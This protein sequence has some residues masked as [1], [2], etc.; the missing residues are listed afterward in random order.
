M[1]LNLIAFTVLFFVLSFPRE[2]FAFSFSNLFGNKDTKS[3]KQEVEPYHDDGT[4]KSSD[5]EVSF[6]V[7]VYANGESSNGI[8]FQ[9]TKRQC[10]EAG[11]KSDK[12]EASL[13]LNDILCPTGFVALSE[14]SRR[15][16][17]QERKLWD[18]EVVH[19]ENENP[20]AGF[21]CALYNSCGRPIRTCNDLIST[22]TK[23]DLQVYETAKL[24]GDI[25]TDCN[26]NGLVDATSASRNMIWTVPIAKDKSLRLFMWPTYRIGHV[27]TLRNIAEE[28]PGSFSDTSQNPIT[29]TTI[30][31]QPKV[32]RIGNFIT[33]EESQYLITKHNDTTQPLLQ[34]STTGTREHSKVSDKRSSDTAFDT[35]SHIALRLKKRGFRVAGIPHYDEQLA[36]GIQM[37]RYN[38][39]NA[40]VTHYDW[41]SPT[42]MPR[43]PAGYRYDPSAAV[44]ASTSGRTGTYL[45]DFDSSSQGTNRFATIFIY[46]NE[47]E[48]G[49]GGET[50]FPHAPP[51]LTTSEE[52]EPI[53]MHN[54]ANNEMKQELFETLSAQGLA[55]QFPIDSWQLSMAAE[56]KTSRTVRPGARQALLFYSQLADGH[57]DKASEHGGCPVISG[58][59]WAA[60]LWIW[61]GIRSGYPHD[62]HDYLG[63]TAWSRNMHGMVTGHSSSL[64][65]AKSG[66]AAMGADRGKQQS[67]QKPAVTQRKVEKPIALTIGL[68][69]E[70]SRDVDKKGNKWVYELYWMSKYWGKFNSKPFMFNSFAGHQWT[71]RRRTRD[72]SAVHAEQEQDEEQEQGGD[73]VYI[74]TC[75]D[76]E[77]QKFELTY[78]HIKAASAEQLDSPV[79]QSLPRVQHKG[80]ERL[81]TQAHEEHAAISVHS[82][83]RQLTEEEEL[84]KQAIMRATGQLDKFKQKVTTQSSRHRDPR[85][86]TTHKRTIGHIG[87]RNKNPDGSVRNPTDPARQP[88]N[89]AVLPGSKVYTQIAKDQW[90]RA[91]L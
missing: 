83:R 90:D 10:D 37:L 48:E 70:L 44:E 46:L 6:T 84:R 78:D 35:S 66:K 88:R 49:Q 14:W 34:R 59:K 52:S 55:E 40:Y 30:Y 72:S 8:P 9:L 80:T 82:G 91:E 4:S 76:E 61:N 13:S 41:M 47:M 3:Q 25:N 81:E 62:K 21:T 71:I 73:I 63:D 18:P 87:G 12:A 67:K 32:F 16:Q 68:S 51:D 33:Q 36:D 57:L 5:K 43:V 56:C 75:S 77:T 64:I 27:Y 23:N 86:E 2:A 1:N 29:L 74:Y 38:V 54:S 31:M 89:R 11:S 19:I 7:L 53:H 85:V 20:P 58:Q 65:N 15:R 79:R 26:T 42:S 22:Y 28:E 39:S 69:T 17:D 24:S 60:N 45:H 50:I